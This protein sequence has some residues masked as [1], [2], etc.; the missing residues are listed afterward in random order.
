MILC[1]T[2][3]LRHVP[4]LRA[5]AHV[6]RSPIV[7]KP[8]YSCR[9]T[10]YPIH[11]TSQELKSQQEQLPGAMAQLLVQHGWANAN[12]Q[13]QQDAAAQAAAPAVAGSAPQGHGPKE[14]A[15]ALELP[16]SGTHQPSPTLASAHPHFDVPGVTVTSFH[17]QQ[18]IRSLQVCGRM[19][20]TNA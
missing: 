12:T 19:R 8:V 13:Q 2:A 3:P 11:A 17:L 10:P 5:H 7:T 9:I 14:K 6:L 15:S 20:L 18:L 16:G 1:C 4:F